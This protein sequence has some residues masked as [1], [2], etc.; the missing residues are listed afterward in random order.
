MWFF[1]RSWSRNLVKESF[2][3]MSIIVWVSLVLAPVDF[4]AAHPLEQAQ[5]IS[6]LNP[7]G[8]NGQVAHGLGLETLMMAIQ[9]WS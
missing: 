7:W 5:L 6:Q 9:G 4:Q 2:Q 8:L 3:K 1:C